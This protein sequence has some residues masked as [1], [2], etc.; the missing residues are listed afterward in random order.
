MAG[1]MKMYG[2]HPIHAEAFDLEQ[3][4]YALD[5]RLQL[6]YVVIEHPTKRGV[7]GRR[8]EVRRTNEDGSESL[9]G[10]WK[11][12]EFDSI[13]VDVVAMKAGAEGRGP[14][15]I[16]QIDA[17][18][19]VIEDKIDRDIRDNLGEMKEYAARLWHDRNNPRNVFRQV[20]G[21]RDEPK[22]DPNAGQ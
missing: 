7:M 11:L 16:E 22:A 6:K 21:L 19:K 14:T 3:K 17:H 5:P 20:G 10:H 1:L 15:A 9:I 18:N 8:Y 13:W 4:L 12:D 2:S